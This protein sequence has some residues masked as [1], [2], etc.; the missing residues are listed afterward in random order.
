MFTTKEGPSVLKTT[1]EQD[2]ET[3]NIEAF[4]EHLTNS[5]SC[6]LVNHDG[7]LFDFDSDFESHLIPRD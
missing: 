7:H 2:K 1:C 4:D 5:I 6:S 3:H